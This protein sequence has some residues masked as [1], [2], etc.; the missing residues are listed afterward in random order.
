[1]IFTV[2]FGD[3]GICESSGIKPQEFLRGACVI[4]SSGSSGTLNAAEVAH[5]RVTPPASIFGA[6]L[7]LASVCDPVLVDSPLFAMR[8]QLST[9]GRWATMKQRGAAATV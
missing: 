7:R 4:E 9:H 8:Q 3:L 6:F 2:R 1:M 5:A